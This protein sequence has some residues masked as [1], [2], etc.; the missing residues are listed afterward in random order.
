LTDSIFTETTQTEPTATLNNLVGEGKKFKTVEDLAKGKLEADQFIDTLKSELNELRSENASRARLEEIVDRLTSTQSNAHQDIY[1]EDN[2]DLPQS[3]SQPQ[4][5][6]DAIER[7]IDQKLTRRERQQTAEQN[8]QAVI[9]EL[10]RLYGPDYVSRLE[11]RREE[12]GLEQSEMNALAARSPTAFMALVAPNQARTTHTAPPRSAVRTEGL[13]AA[14]SSSAPLPGTWA[15][16]ET[17]KKNDPKRYWTPEVQGQLHK[18]AI[19]ANKE[20]REF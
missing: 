8:K 20:G 19:K 12:L 11:T 10:Q 1:E 17:L 15:W 6:Q 4:L 3:P 14:H 18:D 7:L 9:S 16:Y 5:N 13:T 2:Q